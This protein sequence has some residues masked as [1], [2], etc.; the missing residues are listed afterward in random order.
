MAETYQVRIEKLVYGGDGLGR[1]PDGRAVFVP[2]VLPDELVMIE[3][4]EEKARFARGSLVKVIEPSPDR[5]EPR[6]VHFTECGGCQY[7]HLDYAKQLS[8]KESILRDQ[9]TRIAKVENPPLK[10][11]VPSPDP[12]HYRNTVQF[13]IGQYGELGYIHADG[14]HLLPIRECHLPEEGINALWPQLELGEEAGVFPTGHPTGHLWRD[15]A[16]HGRRK[17]ESP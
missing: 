17:P 1:L 2:F 15:H 16:H 13:Q 6:C 5:I 7:Q 8:T 10:P 4:V 3:L 14:E 12:W 11:I 9:F